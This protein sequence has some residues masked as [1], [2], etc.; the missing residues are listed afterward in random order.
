MQI[1]QA[2]FQRQCIFTRYTWLYLIW[3]QTHPHFKHI[4]CQSSIVLTPEIRAHPCIVFT[5]VVV[6]ALLCRQ[7]HIFLAIA[8]PYDLLRAQ[9]Y[10]NPHTLKQ[11]R[12]HNKR[13]SLLAQDNIIENP[14]VSNN[15]S[16]SHTPFITH[17]SD[18][19]TYKYSS[20]RS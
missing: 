5:P 3:L 4:Q 8:T 6:T 12:F 7:L 19:M 18:R 2:S 11:Y 14:P 10:N 9:M 1:R 17:Y 13:I 20:P 15:N 16:R